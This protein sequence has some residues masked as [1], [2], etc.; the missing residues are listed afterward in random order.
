MT[1]QKRGAAVAPKVLE[2]QHRNETTRRFKAFIEELSSP[3]IAS[4]FTPRNYE[5]LYTYK[6]SGIKIH[7]AV[8]SEFR[9]SELKNMK[10]LF[11]AYLKNQSQDLFPGLPNTNLH[12]ALTLGVPLL[13]FLVDAYNKESPIAD[14]LRAH[15][16][17]VTDVAEA[18][19][20]LGER[21]QFLMYVFGIMFSTYENGLIYACND[22]NSKASILLNSVVVKRHLPEKRTFKVE[23]YGREAYRVAWFDLDEPLK[24]LRYIELS[25]AQLGIPDASPNV[26]LKVY[27]QKHA[28]QRI[29]DRL[30]S[31]KLTTLQL[32]LF[33]SINEPIAHIVK[34]GKFLLE[35]R[36]NKVKVGYFV[37]TVEGNALLIRTFL[38]ITNNGTPEGH[39]LKEQTGLQ[40]LDKKYLAIDKLSSFV[41]KE[42]AEN[43][44]IRA[45]FEKADCGYLFDKELQT[46]TAI[47]FSNRHTP[48][49]KLP[50]YIAN[51]NLEAEWAEMPTV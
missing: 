51:H 21:I 17:P 33:D 42:V 25:Q 48:A 30:D 18:Y 10:N 46:Y 9:S 14:R 39:R 47:E 22:E 4:L 1:K 43:A 32:P 7:P 40:M 29:T 49:V 3:E 44:E 26:P 2:A 36:L 15:F 8:D 35:M 11:A 37:A 31:I 20:S 12:D 41:A 38:F 5:L 34:P 45:I 27:I 28:L 50:A 6:R 16:G 24:K 13:V 23:G 19:T